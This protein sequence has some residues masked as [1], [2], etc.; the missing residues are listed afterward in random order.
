MTV[1]AISKDEV[2]AFLDANPAVRWVDVVLFDLNGMPR[3]KRVRRDDL[4]GFVEKGLLLPV[5]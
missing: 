3:G 1:D 5:I 4:E 2:A